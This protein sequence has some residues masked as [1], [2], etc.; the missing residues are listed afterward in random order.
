[1]EKELYIKIL[2]CLHDEWCLAK[3][4]QM[5]QKRDFQTIG[6]VIIKILLEEFAEININQIKQII[7]MR[8]SYSQE[9]Y[10]GLT[11]EELCVLICERVIRFKT[12]PADEYQKIEQNYNE[13]KN[14]YYSII[15][16]IDKEMLR[17]DDLIKI[18]KEHP[19]CCGDLIKKQNRLQAR[20]NVNK[21]ILKDLKKIENEY[22]TLFDLIQENYVYREMLKYAKEKIEAYFESSI[23]LDTEY[24]C[25]ALRK[26]AIEIAQEDNEELK[27][28]KSNFENYDT[29]L[30]SWR[31]AV[32]SIY[33]P[34][35]MVKMRKFLDD[36]EDFYFQNANGAYWDKLDKLFE[37][38][39]EKGAK[40]LESDQWINLRTQDSDKY[41]QELKKY[42]SEFQVLEYLRQKIDS[43]YCLQDR[44]SIL[45][46]IIDSFEDQNYVIFMNLVVIQIEGLLYDMFMD[47]NIQNRLDGQFDL[48]EKDDLKSKM[49]KNDTSMG[50]EEAALYFKFYFNSM[51][52]N[53]VA[54]GRNFFKEEEYEKISYELLLDFQYVIHLLGKHS[55]T[56][57][58]VEYIKD[59][60]RWLGLS[61]TGQCTERQKHEKLLNS[62]NGNVIKHKNNFIGYVDSHQELYWIFNP[63]YEAA[64]EY[65]GVIELRNKLREDLTNE[66]FWNYVLEYIKS[67]D[68]QEIPH[69]KFKREFKSRV[70]AMQEYIAKNK[71]EI[72]P[73]ISE[74]SRI[75]ETMQ[76]HE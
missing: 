56:N 55:D 6:D 49:E 24:P 34:F 11:Y 18:D 60:V 69:I 61:I 2:G 73:L 10:L 20:N 65:A 14:K 63:Y 54:H 21:S 44:K 42:I 7:C 40:I 53:K 48:F 66:D 68:E 4:A 31:N 62:L 46:T 36:I 9:Q 76:L 32:Q 29:C 26:I 43:L 5:V 16:E 64:Y 22:N 27:K 57:E 28:Y 33:K 41:I 8:L 58:A 52:R 59:T 45:N 39:K 70:K 17:I 75:M 12:Y 19:Q 51:I 50:L 35:Y 47:A 37:I 67:Y 38:C 25:F 3:K 15:E 23:F 1:M 74:V 13:I 71:R 72:L 30:E